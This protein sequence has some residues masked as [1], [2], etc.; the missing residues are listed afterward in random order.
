MILPS[1]DMKI[2]LDSPTFITE[3]TLPLRSV[4]LIL[5]TPLP[6][7]GNA[8]GLERRALAVAVLADRGIRPSL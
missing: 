6:P 3:T 8:I 1:G 2:L 7:R 5:V 4:V